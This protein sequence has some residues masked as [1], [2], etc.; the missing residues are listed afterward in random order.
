MA[1]NNNIET[2]ETDV[3]LNSSKFS[4]K[5][6]ADCK[7]PQCRFASGSSWRRLIPDTR[8]LSLVNFLLL[9][10][11]VYHIKKYVILI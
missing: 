6:M 1:C 7:I 10:K 4:W 2:I 3:E 8:H 5:Q 9:N 11:F